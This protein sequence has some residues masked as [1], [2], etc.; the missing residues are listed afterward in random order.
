MFENVLHQPRAVSLL[1]RHIEQDT[2]PQALLLHGPAY[3]GKTTAALELARAL[4]CKTEGAPWSCRCTSC[5]Q[6][7][8]LL[9]PNTLLLGSRYFLQE[10][11]S[12][13]EAVKRE[14]KDATAF[15]FVRAVRKLLRRFDPI[16]WQ[17]EENA[18]S[19][20]EKPLG[21]IAERLTDFEPDQGR[22]VPSDLEDACDAIVADVRKV[23]AGIGSENVPIHVVRAL[24]YWSHLASAG[25]RKIAIIEGADR[26]H[27]GSRNALLKLLEEPPAGVYVVLIS[28]NKQAI[29]PTILS[30]VRP[31]G[32]AERARNEVEDVLVRIF[33]EKPHYRTEDSS[34]VE[35]EENKPQ[36]EYS[37]L[38]EYF[39][40]CSYPEARTLRGLAEKFVDGATNGTDH[41]GIVDHVDPLLRTS[42]DRETFRYFCECLIE[43]T[44][45][46]LREGRLELSVVEE[47]SARL[48]DTLFRY[49][50]LNI[51]A[52]TALH[53]LFERMKDSACASLSSER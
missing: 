46:R 50:T 4:T 42:G 30:R 45:Q 17:S 44:R 6:Q 23:V 18:L 27:E 13:A 10:I 48:Y 41:E 16:L 38:R 31:I 26:M 49:D 51:S 3:S 39:V 35:S 11:I 34:T 40:Y 36:L 2:L 24:S 8:L 29:I 32:V 9:H 37:T 22:P 12:A 53:G 43:Y 25:E 19:K 15:L 5:R 1:R 47:W 33:R 7:R 52:S 28:T 20:I 21:A 14:P